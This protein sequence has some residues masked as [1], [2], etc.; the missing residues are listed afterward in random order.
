LGRAATVLAAA[1]VARVPQGGRDRCGAGPGGGAQGA[2]AMLGV[3]LGRPPADPQKFGRT[4]AWYIDYGGRRYYLAEATWDAT[5]A[6]PFDPR[7]IGFFVGDNP[8]GDA[9]KV[10][11]VIEL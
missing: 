2:H 6:S 1:L 8:W 9:L 7:I 3:D 10:Y 11:R 5:K 4:K